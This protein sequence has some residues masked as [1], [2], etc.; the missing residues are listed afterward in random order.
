MMRTLFF[1]TCAS[2]QI[3]T[4]SAQSGPV[5]VT[6]GEH[7]GYSR[8]AFQGDGADISV[9]QSGRRVTLK[10][11]GRG[12]AF[13]MTSINDRRKAYRILAARSIQSNG[14]DAIELTLNCDCAVRTMTLG[15]GK[16][17]LDVVADSIPTQKV[18]Q[19]TQLMPEPAAEQ[20]PVRAPEKEPEQPK[21]EKV[22]SALE[23]IGGTPSKDDI[24]SVTQAHNQMVALLQQAA[25]EGLITI[26]SDQEKVAPIPVAESTNPT[27]TE[28]PAHQSASRLPEENTDHDAAPDVKTAAAPNENH[29]LAAEV[30][31]TPVTNA[32]TTIHRT[33]SC[34]PDTYIG[35]DG[36]EFE[37][38]PLVAIAEL[39]SALDTGGEMKNEETIL[40]LVDGYLSI[41]FGEEALSLLLDNN[42][43]HDIKAEVARVIAE[44]DLPSDSRLLRAQNCTDTH[45][46]WQAVASKQSD[47]ATYFRR[48]GQAIETLPRRLRALVATRMAIKLIAADAYGDAEKLYQIALA[49]N[50][51]PGAD[52]EYVRARLDQR[53]GEPGTSHDTLLEIASGNTN[54]SDDAL[55]ALAD[56]YAKRD[57]QPHDGFT[58]DIGALAKIGGSTQATLAEADAWAKLGNVDAALFLL[59]SVG[60]KSDLDLDSARRSAQA[61]FD[62]A[63]SNGDASVR[64]SALAAFLKHE[65]WF[66]PEQRAIN[67]KIASA[68]ES[69]NSGLPNLAF[70]LLDKIE[71]H[72][73]TAF[74]KTKAAAALDA[75]FEQEAIAIAAPHTADPAFGEIVVKANLN[76][77]QY[78]AALAAAGALADETAKATWAS[79]AAWM[80]RS[81]TSAAE[82]FRALDPNVLD[83]NTALQFALTAYKNNAAS[84]PPAVDAVLSSSNQTLSAGIRSIFNNSN[85]GSALQRGRENVSDADNEIKMIE[86]ILSDG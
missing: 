13:D 23:R 79:R 39:Q 35:I 80:A 65:S 84:I 57:A 47:T 82:S 69:Q 9:A 32:S 19:A 48:S 41:G 74:L 61:I 73:D 11:V 27:V 55:L 10:N 86:E 83:E 30:A 8:I 63:F 2:L 3:A 40:K 85:G 72:Q 49:S 71:G 17:V 6:A 56:S 29:T 78:N 18:T 26:K 81:W 76:N 15:N 21:D 12:N 34:L 64:A 53:S 60:Q 4:A 46:L 58:E 24:L 50:D 62:D 66:A 33:A 36:T 7:D 42:A 54:A 51:H 37:E 25:S 75:G 1:I 77:G 28:E 59:Q 44:Q 45:A 22:Q 31:A 70:S 67:I 68:N 43:G 5:V 14:Q 38:E 16:F 52:L 20:A